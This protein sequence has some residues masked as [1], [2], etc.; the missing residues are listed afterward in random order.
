MDC[1]SNGPIGLT[2]TAQQTKII[3]I[4]VGDITRNEAVTG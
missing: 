2:A 1:T 4:E 3:A